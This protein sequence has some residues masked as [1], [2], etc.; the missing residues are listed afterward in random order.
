MQVILERLV[1]CVQG[2]GVNAH[3]G[4]CT[5]GVGRFFFK[6]DNA[7]VFVHHHYSK[8][9]G[10]VQR[11]LPDGD[12]AIG[13]VLAMKFQKIVIV[14]LV[15]VVARQDQHV[16]GPGTT[17]KVHVL[18]NG[19]CRALVP[20]RVRTPQ[21]GL[22]ER[23]AAPGPVQVPGPAHADVVVQRTGTVLG[24]DADVVNPRV[25]TVAQGKI[26]DAI[27]ASKG[28]GRLGSFLR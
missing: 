8:A 27:F 17:D 7:V 23:Y 16:L 18:V 22:Q 5:F 12:G 3:R 4:Q 21:K 10:L 11:D 26:N 15:D 20:I 19:V 25:D 1:Q 13:L 6:L 2:K 9:R 14:H 28:H 24:G